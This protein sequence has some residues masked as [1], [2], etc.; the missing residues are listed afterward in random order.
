MI[1]AAIFKKQLSKPLKEHLLSLGFKGSGFHYL[2]E[3]EGFFL[4]VG[5]QGGRY[6]GRCC[7]EFGIQPKSIDSIG[8]HKIDFK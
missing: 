7:V 5:I 4:A 3:I 1:T 6:G 8:E 2:M